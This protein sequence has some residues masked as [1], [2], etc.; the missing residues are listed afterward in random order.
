MD[1]EKIS[2][3]QTQ[4]PVNEWL[5]LFPEELRRAGSIH[6]HGTVKNG[7]KSLLSHFLDLALHNHYQQQKKPLNRALDP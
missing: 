1:G 5:F 3:I 6:Y 4:K 2:I 7:F